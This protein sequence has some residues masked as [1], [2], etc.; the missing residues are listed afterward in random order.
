MQKNNLSLGYS[1]IEIIV[2]ISLISILGYFITLSF[3]V[4]NYEK[5]ISKEDKIISMEQGIVTIKKRS[6][7]KGK[8]LTYLIEEELFQTDAF[9]NCKI[10]N[11][12]KRKVHVTP[13]GE[14]SSFQ[15]D[16]IIAK[17]NWTFYLNSSGKVE[18]HDKK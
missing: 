9:K 6:L 2:V 13:S 5:V 1:L 10:S 8:V 7:A 18:V 12:E 11:N 4:L 3:N 14:V 15:Y 16:C 17:K